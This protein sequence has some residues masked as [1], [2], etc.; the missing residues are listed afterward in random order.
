MNPLS[1]I[2]GPALAGLRTEVMEP[3]ANPRGVLARIAC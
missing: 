2:F 3:M 1:V